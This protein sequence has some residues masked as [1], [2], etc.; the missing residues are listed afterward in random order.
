VKSKWAWRVSV[1]TSALLV[2]GVVVALFGAGFHVYIVSS[3]SMGTTAPVGTLVVV[4][5]KDSYHLGDVVSYSMSKRVYTHRIVDVTDQ[6]FIT[7]GDMNS[8]S[9]AL[10]VAASQIVGSV[11]FYGKD[12]GFLVQALPWLL[13]AWAIVYG[14]SLLPRLDRGWRWHL[15]LIGWSL[16]TSMVGLW[17]RPWVNMEMIDYAA[18]GDGVA[19]HLVNTGIFPVSVLGKVLSSGQDGVVTQTLSD[20]SGRYSVTPQLALNSW[21]FMGLMVFCL[22]PLLVSL[23]V[24]VEVET[25]PDAGV[26]A[27]AAP[28]RKLA[29]VTPTVLRWGSVGLAVTSSI[30]VVAM[31][32]QMTTQAALVAKITDNANSAGTRTYYTCRNA[33]TSSATP[34][35]LAWALGATGGTSEAD[36]S[37]FGRTGK[38]AVTAAPFSTS[39]GCN[40]DTPK[41]AVTF[42]GTSQ[43]LYENANYQTSGYT[44]NT[45]SLEAWFRTS[46]KSGGVIVGFGASRDTVAES[47]WDRHIYLDRDGRVVFGVYPGAVKIV[48]TS[49]TAGSNG[50]GSYADGKWHHV[51]ATL[52]SAG[53]SLY[54]DGQLAK[55]DTTVT[56][57]EQVSGYWKVGCGNLDNWRNA[58]TDATGSTALDYTGPKY[59]TGQIQYAAVYPVALTAAQVLQHY[60]AGA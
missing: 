28:T 49:A 51:I 1:A 25:T 40:Q 21:Y 44:P 58:A 48:Y 30:V 3:P 20:A 15:R 37:T 36:L 5:A 59:F 35:Y 42:N 11:M 33:V 24:P 4:H 10:P 8:S 26:T 16:A 52:S 22:T 32:L 17:F 38:Y 6:G 9:D 34:A 23:L 39:V 41:S 53:E 19:M 7:Q 27:S 31:V 29:W 50:D 14:L 13:I 46:T 2:L 54:V 55:T 57:A 60:Q 43:C 47:N 18:K 12:L 45:F 56:S